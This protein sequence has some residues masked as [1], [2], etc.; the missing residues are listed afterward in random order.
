M[1]DS[2][3][4]LPDAPL[5]LLPL[6]GGVILPGTVRTLPV[7]RRK[8]VALIQ[9]L[10]NPRDRPL[11]AVAVQ[12]DPRINDPTIADLHPVAVLAEVLDIR[13]GQNG[14]LM[15]ALNAVRRFALTAV[16]ASDP[17][18]L[19]EGEELPEPSADSMKARIMAETLAAALKD[20]AG[21][22]GPMK[23]TLDA[24]RHDPSPGRLA[25]RVASVLELTHS[26]Q[27]HV[28]LTL[29]AADRLER[30]TSLAGE[31]LTAA[32]LRKK[33]EATVRQN[34]GQ[35]Q[36]EN[37]LRE[38]MAAIRKELGEDGGQDDALRKRLTEKELPEDIREAVDRELRRLENLGQ[39]AEA[40]VA[41]TWLEWVADLP[42]TERVEV[43]SDL[44]AVADQLDA[45]HYGLD[46][47][48]KRILEHMAVLQL[49]EHA[50]GTILCLTGPPGTGK[51]SLARSVAEATGRPFVRISL[52]GVRDEASIRGHRRTYVGALPGRI[53]EGMRKAK[54]KNP[55]VLLDE[56]DK[57]THGGFSGNPEA[58]LLEVL[59]PA[60]NN[61]FTDHY[62]DL[63]YDLSEVLFICT[64]NQIG[65]LSA[66]LRDRLEVVN[67]DG[68]TPMEKVRIAQAHLLPRQLEAHGLMGKD[69]TPGLELTEA[70]LDAIVRDYTREAGVRQLERE[71]IRLCRGAALR[72]ARGGEGTLAVEATDLDTWL[73]KARFHQQ[74]AERTS[75]PGV[76]TG[77]AWTPVGGDIL[78]I[79]TSRM[80]GRGKLEITG[81][82]G[83][84]MTESARA[85]L[86][87]VR[88]HAEELGISPKLLETEDVH[89]HVPAGATPKD[90][91]SAGV[92]IF[93][94]LTSLFTG[95][96]VRGDV[97]MTGE[98]T[99]RGRVLPVGGIKSKVLA[100]HR[101]GLTR[102]ILPAQNARDLDEL[103]ESVRAQL[104]FTLAED[105][106]TVLAV[107]LEASPDYADA[108][109]PDGAVPGAPLP[110]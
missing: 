6:R 101:A 69:G 27:V 42:W 104:T 65:N 82:L 62:L 56:I 59:D 77:L 31:T 11:V 72:V 21:E 8:S 102:I 92:T 40:Q 3:V 48:K 30:V 33:I 16:V 34:L 85:A 19:A 2:N 66:P 20:Q 45:D 71:L 61:T 54:A 86:T 106:A 87:Y 67:I 36:R 93:T 51:T 49:A 91:P 81:Q 35:R 44:N 97:A 105:M 4:T 24:F 10:G 60:Q 74:V 55:V 96:R 76:A 37:M 15:V 83:D 57:L 107:A 89:I 94:A 14:G 79:E 88:S 41:R 12:R 78:F 63:P 100:A 68:Y 109:L 75:L 95:R 46:E 29:D 1:A 84:V 110:S 32:D 28:L 39:G 103:P 50:K 25:D 80:P 99:L 52:G 22:E 70:A 23:A 108:D 13:R 17:F 98:C 26:Q 43:K 58:A 18:M 5:P 64:S 73:G 47:V 53:I 90:G 7:G 9:S 38:Q